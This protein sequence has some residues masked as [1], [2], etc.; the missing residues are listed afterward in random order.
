MKT[1]IPQVFVVNVGMDHDFDLYF[2]EGRM[3]PNCPICSPQPCIKTG[4][5]VNNLEITKTKYNETYTRKISDCQW[6]EEMCK[7]VF[8]MKNHM[9]ILW[10]VELFQGNKNIFLIRK[11]LGDKMSE[12][13]FLGREGAYD[14]PDFRFDDL[15]RLPQERYVK[16][17]AFW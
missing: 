6:F 4:H 10:G 11:D 1:H 5:G 9:W 15:T 7:E 13:S 17:T 2:Y 16:L 3:S 14:N 8:A 12:T